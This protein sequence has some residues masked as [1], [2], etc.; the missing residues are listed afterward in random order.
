MHQTV[1]RVD[2]YSS[3]QAVDDVPMRRSSQDRM[4]SLFGLNV[5]D[6]T[7]D[8]AAGWIVR[9]PRRFKWVA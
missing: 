7:I 8:N 5:T 2:T 1:A 3:E 9:A 4:I 6:T